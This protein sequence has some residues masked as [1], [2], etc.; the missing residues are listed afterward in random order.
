[1]RRSGG[2][3]NESGGK[4]EQETKQRRQQQPTADAAGTDSTKHDDENTKNTKMPIKSWTF[5]EWQQRFV[6]RN[7]FPFK[8]LFWRI[9]SKPPV[10]FMT[11]VD[12]KSS[13]EIVHTV[14]VNPSR[15]RVTVVFRG[16]VTEIGLFALDG[17]AG[18]HV[19]TIWNHHPFRGL[20]GRTKD[21]K[22]IFG[23]QKNKQT[24]ITRDGATD[25]RTPKS[26]QQV[27]KNTKTRIGKLV[28]KGN[29]AV[30]DGTISI[31]KV[32]SC[33]MTSPVVLLPPQQERRVSPTS[34]GRSIPS[35]AGSDRRLR[36]ERRK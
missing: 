11:F 26:S 32:E 23:R 35:T 1:M 34:T 4:V 30:Q 28:E 25:K 9:N 21:E 5:F 27:S 20:Y 33:H 31:F 3:I 15:K 6:F 8:L 14:V 24:F 36:S 19:S 12:D 22:R 10:L 16:S 7:E 17:Q 2:N 29:D 18:R 13:E